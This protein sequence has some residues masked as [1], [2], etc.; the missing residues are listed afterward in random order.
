MKYDVIVA[1]GGPA[2]IGAAVA[3]ARNG[4]KTLLIEASNARGGM[5][6]NGLVPY[7]RT[8]GDN[9]GII[10]E[11]WQ[12]MVDEGVEMNGSAVSGVYVASK[13][14]RSF[15]EASMFVDATGDGNLFAW[16]DALFSKGR[17]EDGRLQA[18]SLNFQIGG[19][20]RE[21]L[22]PKEEF[23]AIVARAIQSGELDMTE[24]TFRYLSMGAPA[25][26]LPDNI[27]KYQFDFDFDTDASE[28]VSYSRGE[29]ICQQRVL[30]FWR[31]LKNQITGFENAALVNLAS[32]L[33]VRET[34]RIHGLE[35]MTA[36][37]VMTGRK[38]P[39][40]I[41][42]CSWYMDIHDEQDKIPLKEYC[43]ARACPPGDYFEIPYGCLISPCI[44]NLLGAGRFISSTRAANGA[45]R[46]QATCMNTGQA[47][48][49][50]A[51]VCHNRK[52]KAQD[53]KGSELRTI[54][55]NQG[56]EI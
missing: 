8:A 47:A 3:S 25:P 7:I 5:G 19:I 55:I 37:D 15:F 22:P 45:I 54:L 14:G 32:S 18:V 30:Q 42:R 52:L 36:E 33:G 23:K 40:G 34:R 46:L 51:A 29:I 48:G 41:C 1:G 44:N 38:R 20:D 26:G 39:D 28:A 24:Y 43:A 12:R 6:T 11:Y 53:L 21:K 31:F 2:G 9:G 10:N 4:A 13:N 50:A 56:I 35:I 17:Q 49:T 16:A 27:H